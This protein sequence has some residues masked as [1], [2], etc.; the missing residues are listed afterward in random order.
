MVQGIRESKLIAV[1]IGGAGL[2]ILIHALLSPMSPSDG[3]STIGTYS[4]SSMLLATIGASMFAGGFVHVLFGGERKTIVPLIPA[5][6]GHSVDS[7]IAPSQPVEMRAASQMPANQ[8][9][10]EFDLIL[11]LLNGDE[12]I[13][14]RAIVDSGGEA[15]QKDLILRTNMSN[16]KVSRILDRLEGMGLITKA[17]YGSTNRIEIRS[18][19]NA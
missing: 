7:N 1:I 13:L 3:M 14:F 11:R 9:E 10:R 16:A 6:P 15:L 2:F 19:C 18:E 8:K 4:D 5:P 17:R 12:R